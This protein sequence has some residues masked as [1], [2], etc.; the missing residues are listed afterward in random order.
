MPRNY[1]VIAPSL[2][3]TPLAEYTPSSGQ[4]TALKSILLDFQDGVNRRDAAKVAGLISEDA[5]LMVGRER[6]LLSKP[7]YVKVLPQRLMDNPPIIAAVLPDANVIGYQYLY[8]PYGH[9]LGQSKI[10][11]SGGQS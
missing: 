1:L 4:E 11:P 9:N 7:E 5:S 2:T 6:R 8:I 10:P 3:D